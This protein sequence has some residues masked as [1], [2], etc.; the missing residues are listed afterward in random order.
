MTGFFFLAEALTVSVSVVAL[1][2]LEFV[3]DDESR[4]ALLGVKRGRVYQY[5]KS[6][7]ES[8]L[9]SDEFETDGNKDG[10]VPAVNDKEA[11]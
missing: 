9:S 1:A 3:V 11:S 4:A 2:G 8:T 5:T 6:S 7:S 10:I